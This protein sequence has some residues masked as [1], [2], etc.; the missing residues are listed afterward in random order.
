MK[1][2]KVLLVIL[3][4]VFA[5]NVSSAQV[6]VKIYPKRGTVVTKINKPRVIVHK[7]VSYYNADGVWYAKKRRGYVVVGAPV[8]VTVKQLPSGYRVVKVNGRKY[9]KYR[10][11]VYKKNKRRYVVVNV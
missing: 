3:L 11:V 7:N 10:G 2:L 6:T 5:F 8:G 1:N 9:Y 4:T